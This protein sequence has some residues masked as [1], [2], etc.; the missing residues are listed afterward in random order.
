MSKFIVCYHN[1]CTDGFTAAFIAYLHFKKLN[2]LDMVEFVP[3]NP[4]T[5]PDIDVTD[6]NVVMFD[7]CLD[8]EA[9]NKWSKL[10]LSFK[11]YDHHVS[12]QRE[13]GYFDCCNFDLSKS[14]A[15][16]AWNYYNPDEPMPW[17]VEYVQDAD[18]W[19]WKLPH[20][21]E[22]SVF[23]KSLEFSF[24]AYSVLL[25]MSYKD[26]YETGRHV[27]KIDELRIKKSAKSAMK[28]STQK[29]GFSGIDHYDVPVVNS[30]MFQ[31]EIGNFLA[32]DNKFSIVWYAGESENNFKYAQ[33]SFRSIGDFD[34]SKI[35]GSFGGGGHKNAAGVRMPL[36]EWIN[37]IK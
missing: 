36:Q 37:L 18:L 2:M 5:T 21:K 16:L 8:K 13:F 29:L 6:C 26:A 7:V 28:I 33:L 35:A 4:K 19:T 1:S 27:W 23:L 31:S 32:Q 22:V 24:E 25:D 9:L 14:G 15:G 17:W 30:P 20:S 12:N 10:A 34:V 11:V 3:V